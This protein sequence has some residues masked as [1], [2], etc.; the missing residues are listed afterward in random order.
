MPARG[1]PAVRQYIDDH[2]QDTDADMSD[3]DERADPD[4]AEGL[5]Q[6]LDGQDF[7]MAGLQVGHEGRLRAHA[8]YRMPQQY[9]GAATPSHIPQDDNASMYGSRP[10]SPMPNPTS[11]PL[12]SDFGDATPARIP[13]DG[14]TY[15]SH[16]TSPMAGTQLLLPAARKPPVP[17]VPPYSATAGPSSSTP[18][19]L[20]GSR[21]PT[22]FTSRDPREWT[23]WEPLQYVPG[24]NLQV[25]AA[26]ST[27]SSSNDPTHIAPEPVKRKRA[28]SDSGEE[29]TDDEEQADEEDEEEDLALFHGSLTHPAS[30][31]DVAAE[32]S[33]SDGGSEADD[34][35]D[36][37]DLGFI[38][39]A[40]QSRHA[41]P[42][43]PKKN[44]LWGRS[45]RCKI[46]P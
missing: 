21:D 37:E 23:P 27:N 16:P 1:P 18:L 26:P 24:Q 10:T 13:D 39:D 8:P 46:Y 4:S 5:I 36:S 40:E 12:L 44:T 45:F 15:P 34:S 38:D 42:A 11:A 7:D 33:D 41:S 32:D 20:P 28:E 30:F 22:P 9:L 43:P 14:N 25:P 19:F 17:A 3:D 31:L 29:R 35:E 2:A 6:A